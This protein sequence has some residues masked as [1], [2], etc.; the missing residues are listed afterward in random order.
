M[1]KV[2]NILLSS[3][4]EM[5]GKIY[6]M[7]IVDGKE[8]FVSPDMSCEDLKFRVE[9]IE[10]TLGIKLSLKDV[11]KYLALMGIGV[12]EE[13]GVLFA[14]IPCYRADILHWI[15]LS[16]EVAIAY[17]YDNFVPE[18]PDIS[19]IGE[20]N[21]VD[22]LKRAVGNV[23]AGVGMLECSSFHLTTKKNVKKMHYDFS[24]FIEL[25]ESKTER[26]VLRYD[27]MS[28]L[29]QIFSENSDAAYPQKIFEMGRVFEKSEKSDS[30]VLEK[31]R[32]G[33]AMIDER[34][35]F[36]EMKQVVDYLFKMMGVDYVVEDVEDSNY[37]A[38]RIGKVIVD[39]KEV[40]RIGEIAPR[41]LRNWK[42]RM[43]VVA[44]EIGIGAFG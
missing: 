33:I 17:G 20:E 19:T 30:G 15:D 11:K 25:E 1:K 32:L 13:K 37:I 39:G 23:L 10:K 9:D 14:E 34:M 6:A 27:L 8:S 40:G 29:L 42:I 18:I 7:K 21:S 38:G 36:T 5:G 26:D 41:V 4:S 2:L 12:R 43:P 31:E 24:D 44:C 28:N 3:V 22:K 35:G 16:E